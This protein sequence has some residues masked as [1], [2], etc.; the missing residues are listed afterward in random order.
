MRI[1]TCNKY[2]FLNGGTERY[3]SL[4]LSAL[5]SMG[6]EVIPFSVGYAGS[7]PSPY[8]SFFLPPPG[9]PGGTHFHHIRRNPF[10]MLK[11]VERAAYS[12]QARQRLARL[13]QFVGQVDIGYLLNICN[14]M[15]PSI[16]DTFVARGIP[17]VL[18]LG[19]YHLLCASYTL[20]RN[21][22]PCELCVKGNY[23]HGLQ[24]RCVKNNLAAS[25]L[26][27]FSMY[28]QRWIKIWKKVSAFITPCNFMRKKL[29]EGGFPEERIYILQQPTDTHFIR[30][31]CEKGNY[32]LYFG[33][34]SPE[35][36]L[37]TLIKAYQQSGLSEQLVFIGKSYD[38]CQE[39]LETLIL[40]TFKDRIQF[41]GFIDGEELSLWVARALLT[42][43]PS[44]WY[45]NAPMSI[46]ESYQAGT[47]VLG[48]NIGGIPELI[49]N[50]VTGKLFTPGKVEELTLSLQTLLADRV[51]LANMGQHAMEYVQ[52]SHS[53]KKHM[54]TLL[55]LFRGIHNRPLHP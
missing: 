38:G 23:F 2:F 10:T 16:I 35:K 13:L 39:Y 19:D 30:Q 24:H 5:P 52:K 21:N 34:I 7:W 17:V 53:L 54:D 43:V 45:D 50:N 4:L 31:K 27:V 44:R 22:L 3:L 42:V 41:L 15:S 51:A 33:R 18:R 6:H 20:L 1:L 28:M 12:F 37:D 11:H 8:A 25:T 55:A 46:I 48:A 26:R 14:Y 40:P 49:V 29:V 32:V 9:D 36:G 47:P